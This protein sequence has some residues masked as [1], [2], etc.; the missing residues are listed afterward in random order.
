MENMLYI[1]VILTHHF[2]VNVVVN[3]IEFLQI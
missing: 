2:I 3:H 1:M